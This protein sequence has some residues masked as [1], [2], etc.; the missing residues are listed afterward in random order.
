M[1]HVWL[2]SI[3][4]HTRPDVEQY[5][6]GIN[7][8]DARAS[9]VVDD[10]AE[11]FPVLLGWRDAF[12]NDART[13]AYAMRTPATEDGHLMPG[14]QA[15]WDEVGPP[16]RLDVLPG[17]YVKVSDYSESEPNGRPPFNRSHILR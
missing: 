6:E 2:M 1:R 7:P 9:A 5:A 3:A 4:E 12:P 10:F 13:T 16:Y 15:Q 11:L 14:W 17:G 8:K